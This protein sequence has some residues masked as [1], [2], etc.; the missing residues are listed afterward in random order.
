VSGGDSRGSDALL[1]LLLSAQLSSEALLA[2]E[3]PDIT[4]TGE[5]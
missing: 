5:R 3:G 1:L 2:I 4:E